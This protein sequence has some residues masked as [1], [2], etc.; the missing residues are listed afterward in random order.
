MRK[1][2]ITV[3]KTK[4][5][6]KNNTTANSVKALNRISNAYS[7]MILCTACEL[8]ESYIRRVR[9]LCLMLHI[10]ALIHNM[11][12]ICAITEYSSSLNCV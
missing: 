3:T 8:T 11:I 5:D 1:L 9:M 7:C 10:F 2:I 4:C 12:S 6:N